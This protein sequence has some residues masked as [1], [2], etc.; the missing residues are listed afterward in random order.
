MQIGTRAPVSRDPA[1][2]LP[3]AFLSLG[4]YRGF[5]CPVLFFN[6]LPP[7]LLGLC[8]LPVLILCLR[9]RLSNLQGRQPTLGVPGTKGQRAQ[10]RDDTLSAS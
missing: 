8:P 6:S 4:F 9:L 7:P 2:C 1:L 5:S 10:S 3:T